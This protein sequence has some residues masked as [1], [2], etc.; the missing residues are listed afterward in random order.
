MNGAIEYRKLAVAS[1]GGH[2]VAAANAEPDNSMATGR[3]E[4]RLELGS[5]VSI[6]W[7]DGG[8]AIIGRS[9]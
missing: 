4:N 7:K 5:K 3:S 1:L 2:G 6:S 8:L 9:E